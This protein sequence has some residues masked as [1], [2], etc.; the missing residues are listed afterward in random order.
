M[1]EIGHSGMAVSSDKG[2]SLDVHPTRKQE[3]GERLARWALNRN[4]GFENVVPSGPLYK[5]V[6]FE[7]GKAFVSFDYAEGMKAAQEGDKLRTF[8]I[9]GEDE[10]FYP[11]QAVV[12]DG[13]VKVWAKEVKQPK[14][15][16]Y[17]WQPFTR[18]NLVN[19]EGLPASTF[20]TDV[21]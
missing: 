4:Y 7:K 21:E 6:S 15:V 14:I 3:I 18:A 9:A 10:V 8:E 17:G 12:E 1:D 16:R 2:D 13:K 19:A 5:S 20:R 11:A